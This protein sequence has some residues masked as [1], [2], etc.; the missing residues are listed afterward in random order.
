MIH[1]AMI[2]ANIRNRAARIWLPPGYWAESNDRGA[3]KKVRRVTDRIDHNSCIG[4]ENQPE[5][6]GGGGNNKGEG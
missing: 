3:G 5:V 1:Q 6:G 4:R 2:R